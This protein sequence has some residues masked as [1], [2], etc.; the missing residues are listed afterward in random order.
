MGKKSRTKGSIYERKIAKLFSK[1]YGRNLRRVPLSGGLDIK[2]DIYD[3]FNDDFPLWIECKNRKNFRFAHL[4]DPESA[5]YEFLRKTR[6][7]AGNSYLVKKYNRGPTPIVVFYGGEFTYDMV[8]L[9]NEDIAVIDILR[10]K[11]YVR[12]DGVT[13][14]P[15]LYFLSI[16][17]IRKLPPQPVERFKTEQEDD[18]EQ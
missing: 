9:F 17:F 10:M 18:G 15:L 7:D 11:R 16:L 13:F 14:V 12:C 8:M 4:F 6:I 2:C 1:A 3:P 5:L